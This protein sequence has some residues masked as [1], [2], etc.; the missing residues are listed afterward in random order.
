[1]TNCDRCGVV[2]DDNEMYSYAEV[3]ICNSVNNNENHNLAK[4]PV[5]TG[6][7]LICV[8]CTSKVMGVLTNGAQDILPTGD[9]YK[10]QVIERTVREG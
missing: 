8:S 4:F 10:Y 3:S 1:M 7:Q 9:Q 2:I 5:S 6:R